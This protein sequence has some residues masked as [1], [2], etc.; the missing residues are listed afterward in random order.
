[1][2]LLET[3]KLKLNN[4]RKHKLNDYLIR[5]KPSKKIVISKHTIIL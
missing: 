2:Q 3:L 5:A 1:M 4:I